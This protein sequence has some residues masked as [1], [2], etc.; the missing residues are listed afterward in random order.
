MNRFVN[1]IS[2]SWLR[3][4]IFALIALLIYIGA[5]VAPTLL[6]I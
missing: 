3:T 4:T 6:L 1:W 5:W 2:T